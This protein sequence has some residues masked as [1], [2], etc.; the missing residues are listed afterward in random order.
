MT[1]K[2]HT[3][4][5][6]VLTIPRLEGLELL[7]IT[8]STELTYHRISSFTQNSIIR[9]LLPQSHFPVLHTFDLHL[10]ARWTVDTPGQLFASDYSRCVT[11]V[12]THYGGQSTSLRAPHP[13]RGDLVLVAHLPIV[14]AVK[15]RT[16]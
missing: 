14:P 10:G 5:K 2:S 3:T 12:N 9:I 11:P 4:A 13:N 6:I 8:A 1:T 15:K 7:I 16:Q